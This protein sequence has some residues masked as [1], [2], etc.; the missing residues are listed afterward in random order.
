MRPECEKKARNIR[1]LT[2]SSCHLYKIPVTIMGARMGGK[3]AL[4]PAPPPEFEK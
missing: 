4:P 3:G 2:L 1:R